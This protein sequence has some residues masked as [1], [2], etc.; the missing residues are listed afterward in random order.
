[1][2]PNVHCNTGYNC[3]D[4]EQPKYTSTMD[5]KDVGHI[6]NGLLY[7]C[8]HAQSLSHVQLF[9][10]P[11]MHVYICVCVCITESVCCRPEIKTTL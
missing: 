6:Y 5:K 4:M 7:V 11:Y 2:H 9:V 10:T 8:V 3:Q 1:M